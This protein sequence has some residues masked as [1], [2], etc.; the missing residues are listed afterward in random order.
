MLGPL[1][2]SL[3]SRNT[4]HR[5]YLPRKV[6]PRSLHLRLRRAGAGVVPDGK[7]QVFQARYHETQPRAGRNAAGRRGL[8][9]PYRS[10][11]ERSPGEK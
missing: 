11:Q 2:I 1:G 6:L 4:R 3:G 9:L 7:P 10:L 8:V 5:L